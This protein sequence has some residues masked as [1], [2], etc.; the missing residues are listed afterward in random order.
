MFES[1]KSR[2]N[3]VKSPFASIQIGVPA[4]M[5]SVI[6]LHCQDGFQDWFPRSLGDVHR[7]D[8]SYHIQ[9]GA[10]QVISWFIIH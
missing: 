5:G 2:Y 9:G 1:V 3:Q 7:L 4:Q 10:L 8:R 6:E